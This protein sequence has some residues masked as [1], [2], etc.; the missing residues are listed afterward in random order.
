MDAIISERD[1]YKTNMLM[2]QDMLRK[3]GV[4]LN[5]QVQ[6]HASYQA[7]IRKDRWHRGGVVDG[8]GADGAAGAQR[9]PVEAGRSRQAHRRCA[10]SRITAKSAAISDDLVAKAVAE[11]DVTKQ[12]EYLKEA[13]LQVL[14]DVP[15]ITLQTAPIITAF[16]GKIDLGYKPVTALRPVRLLDRQN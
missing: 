3:I 12:L 9:V 8:D 2:V 15:L 7:N 14:K 10:T 1:D 16:Q 13:Q 11:T 4:N 5:L 6:D